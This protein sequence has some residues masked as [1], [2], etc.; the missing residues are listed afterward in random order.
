[1]RDEGECGELNNTRFDHKRQ[2]LGVLEGSGVR[3][4]PPLTTYLLDLVALFRIICTPLIK[5][6]P[7]SSHQ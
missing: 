5:H 3:L 2:I 4:P 6:C 1:M 7:S